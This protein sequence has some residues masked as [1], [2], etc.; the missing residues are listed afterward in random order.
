MKMTIG[1]EVGYNP[2]AKSFS[3]KIRSITVASSYSFVSLGTEAEGHSWMAYTEKTSELNI[4]KTCR[5]IKQ[6]YKDVQKFLEN[7]D[8]DGLLNYLKD[9]SLLLLEM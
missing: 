9:K 7:E 3:G 6:I 1:E 8:I 2:T 5:E 4:S